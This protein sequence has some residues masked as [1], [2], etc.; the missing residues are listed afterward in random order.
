MIETSGFFSMYINLLSRYLGGK[1]FGIF[2]P[3][4]R[5][6]VSI[7]PQKSVQFILYEITYKVP[8]KLFFNMLTIQKS[9]FTCFYRDK[10]CQN[11]VKISDFLMV[12]GIT[13]KVIIIGQ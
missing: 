10:K 8:G 2:Q 4:Y 11:R 3:F 13:H 7:W 1:E 5:Y 12:L 6:V 9:A